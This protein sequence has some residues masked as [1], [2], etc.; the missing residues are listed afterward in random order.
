MSIQHGIGSPSENKL[1]RKEMR[2]LSGKKRSKLAL[3]MD[4]MLSM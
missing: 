4:D 2:H 3:F 1:G